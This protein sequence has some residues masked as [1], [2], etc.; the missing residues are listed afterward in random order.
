MRNEEFRLITEDMERLRDEVMSRVRIVR[1]IRAFLTS[2][3]SSATL[4]VVFLLCTSIFVSF[5]DIIHNIMIQ[6]E[7]GG[8]VSYAY[9]AVMNTRMSVQVFA[10]LTSLSLLVLFTKILFRLRTPMYIIGSFLSS[11]SRFKFFR[12]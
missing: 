4:V 7:W 1:K 9:Q 6:A 2:P 11:F 5:T 12:S 8:R 3:A 10:F